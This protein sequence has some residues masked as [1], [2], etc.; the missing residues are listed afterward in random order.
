MKPGP[1]EDVHRE[2]M[3][4]YNPYARAAL[5][6]TARVD[7]NEPGAAA[8]LAVR[9]PQV[10]AA[11]GFWWVRALDRNATRARCFY[12]LRELSGPEDPEI[13]GLR[14][15]DDPTRLSSVNRPVMSK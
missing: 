13:I 7:R 8:E 9:F 4:A 14:N 10:V 11:G 2:L 12:E 15:P 1:K 3:N 5:S 6:I